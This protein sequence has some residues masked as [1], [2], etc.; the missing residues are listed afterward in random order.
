MQALIDLFHA[1]PERAMFALFMGGLFVLGTVRFLRLQARRRWMEDMPTS[2]IR[3]ASQGYVELEGSARLMD[4]LPVIS[5]LTHTDCTWWRFKVEKREQ[6]TNNRTRWV[7]VR[8][9]TSTSL[10]LLDDGTGQCVIDPDDAIVEPAWKRVW[11]GD[12]PHPGMQA[13]TSWWQANDYRYTEELIQPGEGLYALGWFTSHDPLHVTPNERVRDTVIAW[14]TDPA[15]R[16]RFDADGNGQLDDKEFAALRDEARKSAM[17]EHRE[18]AS[19]PQTHVL[20]VDPEGRPF[21]LSTHDQH[22]LATRLRI[23]AWLWLAGALAAL[24]TFI[25]LLTRGLPVQM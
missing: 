9:G 24:G 11:R 1:D 14:K 17:E 25:H 22:Q 8:Q 23:Q 6:G 4:G 15:I 13:S 16:K 20:K 18:M 21:I 7:T 19:G 12:T 10:F 2:L 5:P 3:S